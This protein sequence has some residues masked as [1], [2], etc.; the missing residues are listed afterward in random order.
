MV[1]FGEPS[2]RAATIAEATRRSCDGGHL[3]VDVY[4]GSLCAARMSAM[5]EALGI[6]TGL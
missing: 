4:P 2:T 6:C 1:D 5:V 3:G